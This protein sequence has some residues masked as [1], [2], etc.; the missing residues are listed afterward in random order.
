[1]SHH[2][3]E[4]TMSDQRLSISP[5][6]C[7]KTELAALVELQ[8]PV[9]A[10]D[11][12][13][14]PDTAPVTLVEY[15]DFECPYC[16]RAFHAIKWVQREL[17]DQLRFVYRNFPLR[18][19]HPHAQHAAEAAEAAAAQGKFWEMHDYLFEHQFALE[20]ADLRQYAARLGLDLDCFEQNLTEH[21]FARRIERDLQGGIESGVPG[22]PTFF[23]NGVRHEDS[24]DRLSLLSAIQEAGGL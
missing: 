8:V 20:D 1:V 24:Y 12:V 5:A 7:A 2:R 3:K 11:H 17:R 9:I 15:G 14:G 18:E 23:I 22:T 21:R 10:Q 19:I 6:P 4:S 13:Q 16:R